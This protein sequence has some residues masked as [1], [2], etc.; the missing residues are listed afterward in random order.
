MYRCTKKLTMMMGSIVAV[1]AALDS[2]QSTEIAP[3][4]LAMP[5][6]SV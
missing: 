1:A 3:T 2:P 4:K 6:G 5:T